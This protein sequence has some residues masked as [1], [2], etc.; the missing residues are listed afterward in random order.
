MTDYVIG[1]QK[2]ILA[3]TELSHIGLSKIKFIHFIDEAINN[4][5]PCANHTYM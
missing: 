5:D 1:A 3:W 4:L 2:V